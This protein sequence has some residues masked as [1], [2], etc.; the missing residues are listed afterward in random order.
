MI[1]AGVVVVIVLVLVLIA[2]AVGKLTRQKLQMDVM[3]KVGVPD[4]LVPYLAVIELV[5]AV[6]LLVG[7]AVPWVGIAAG[8]GVV[9]YFVGAVVSHLRVRDM[10]L[11]A[12]G[13]VLALSVAALVLRALTV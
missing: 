4:R 12:S 5:G 9:L 2:S 7:F 3:R 1:V 8:I 13:G 10:D 6:G 11:A